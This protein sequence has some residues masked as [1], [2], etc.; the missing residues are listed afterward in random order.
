[1]VFDMNYKIFIPFGLI[2]IIFSTIYAQTYQIDLSHV[3]YGKTGRY[4]VF[5]IR[6]TG[7]TAI[8]DITILIDGEEHSTMKV[9]MGS[10]AGFEKTLYL[11]PGEH[12]IEV[13]SSEGAY[14]SLSI[15]ILETEEKPATN[16]E[17]LPFIKENKL[18]IGIVILIVI[19]V[20]G[21]WL[22][23]RKPELK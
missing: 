1:M 12:L 20:I 9:V 11:E 22:F 5:V 6:N 13:R 17:E 4:A 14:D 7:E 23:T 18:Y 2:L 16:G 15:N 10:G 3:G 19:L 8:R 21:I